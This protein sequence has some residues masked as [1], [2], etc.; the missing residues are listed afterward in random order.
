MHRNSAV[1][2]RAQSGAALIVALILLLVITMLAISTVG[3]SRLEILMAG[4]TQYGL[5][6]FQAAESAIEAEINRGGL[7]TNLDRQTTYNYPSDADATTDT[8]YIISSEVPTG[9]YSLGAGFKAYHFEIDA[10]GTAPRNA[11]SDQRQGFY[12]VGPGS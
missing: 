4:N 6:A 11:K 8:D 1:S 12:I 7:S 9:G 5:Q 3:T 2:A 10:D